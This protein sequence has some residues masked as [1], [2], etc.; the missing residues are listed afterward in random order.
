MF[1]SA[2]KINWKDPVIAIPALVT[3]L[4]MPATFNISNGL[5]LGFIVMAVTFVV[6]F[7]VRIGG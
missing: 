7:T 1:S 5:G 3:I 6:F 4:A 2:G